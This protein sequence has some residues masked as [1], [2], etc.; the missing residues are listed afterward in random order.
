MFLEDEGIDMF[1][2]GVTEFLYTRDGRYK[3]RKLDKPRTELSYW[4]DYR[5]DLE[6]DNAFELSERKFDIVKDVC[7]CDN[8]SYY[9]HFSN[10]PRPFP[11][12]IEYLEAAAV[13]IRHL[14]RNTYLDLSSQGMLQGLWKN[15][16]ELTSML[17]YKLKKPAC[18]VDN[19]LFCINAGRLPT[20]KIIS[21]KNL[22]VCY[23]GIK[24]VNYRGKERQQ[25]VAKIISRQVLLPEEYQYMFETE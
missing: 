13:K 18:L 14:V 12:R 25:I 22:V 21:F 15:N 3:W 6:V 19:M 17:S 16:H 2:S 7:L 1:D 23:D 20:N 9:Y 5:I 11:L 8:F 24:R 10:G 4:N